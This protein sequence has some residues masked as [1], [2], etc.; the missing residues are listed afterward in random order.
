MNSQIAHNFRHHPPVG[1]AVVNH[2]RIRAKAQELAELIEELLPQGAGR[3]RASAITK[4]EEAMFWANAGIARHTPAPV[5]PEE[6]TD[7]Y[8]TA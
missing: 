2:Q 1:D 7:R 4:C 6:R 5:P 8:H 3:E